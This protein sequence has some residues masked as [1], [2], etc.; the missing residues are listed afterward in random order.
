MTCRWSL[1]LVVTVQNVVLVSTS[2]SCDKLVINYNLNEFLCRTRETSL[3][4]HSFRFC[5]KL[6]YFQI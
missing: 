4:R 2:Y 1:T 6:S 3:I 5:L